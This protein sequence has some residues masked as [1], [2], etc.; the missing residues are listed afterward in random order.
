LEQDIECNAR[1][2]REGIGVVPSNRSFV[3]EFGFVACVYG[4]LRCGKVI[5]QAK[6]STD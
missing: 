4:I 5:D 3:P 6:L 2:A 1:I